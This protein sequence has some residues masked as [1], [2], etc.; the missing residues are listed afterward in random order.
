MASK[1]PRLRHAQSTRD[2]ISATKKGIPRPEAVKEKIRQTMLGRKHTPD[3]IAKMTAK[4][5]AR[6]K[7]T[8]WQIA[9]DCRLRNKAKLN[10]LDTLRTER[11]K[12]DMRNAHRLGLLDLFRDVEQS[13]GWNSK[14]FVWSTTP[15]VSNGY[16]YKKKRFQWP[17]PR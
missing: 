8:D 12:L 5:R 9:E 2:K 7:M 11:W 13:Y 1:L 15:L 17:A 16:C 14:R 6:R 3:A 4:R 10:A